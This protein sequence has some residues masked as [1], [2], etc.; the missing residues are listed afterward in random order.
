MDFDFEIYKNKNFSS[1]CKD[2]VSNSEKRKSFIEG[3]IKKII[4]LATTVSEAMVIYP[5][6]TG[7]IDAGTKNDEQLIKLAGVLQKIV[8]KGEDSSD[9]SLLITEEEKKQ[10]LEL[11]DFSIDIEDIKEKSKIPTSK[12]EIEESVNN[13]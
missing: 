4:S 5:L 8:S 11:Q 3:E 2:I 12:N 10:L 6:V 13:H 9:V 1:L 7:L